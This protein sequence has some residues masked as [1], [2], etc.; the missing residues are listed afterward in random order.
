MEVFGDHNKIIK[1]F[2][3][4]IL[5]KDLAIESGFQSDED[6]AETARLK[7]DLW[8]VEKRLE[9]IWIQKSRLKWNVEG[10]KNTKFFHIMASSY[11]RNNHISSFLWMELWEAGVKF[12]I[13]GLDF[14]Q[15]TELQAASLIKPF[16]A[17]EGPDGFNFYFNHRA[18][19][20]MKDVIV[21]FFAKFHKFST[22]T[23]G[24]ISSVMVLV[25][26]MARSSNIKDLSPY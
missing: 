12:D 21:D 15:I 25:P 17:P 19:P 3:E 14:D 9:S 26:K 10:D 6:M 24:I 2:A 11:Y 4:N 8:R 5:A 1:E 23:K 18:L 22:L 7:V 16:Q 13:D 20:M